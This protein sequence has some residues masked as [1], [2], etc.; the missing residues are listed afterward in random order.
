MQRQH[1]RAADS[2]MVMAC[3]R[4]AASAAARRRHG[5]NAALRIGVKN[6]G[7]GMQSKSAAKA[8]RLS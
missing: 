8:P 1:G 2:I 3:A 7:S 6:G 4:L 5:S